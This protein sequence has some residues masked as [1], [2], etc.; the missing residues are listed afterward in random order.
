MAELASPQ[1]LQA[2]PQSLLLVVIL[3]GM[4]QDSS[5]VLWAALVPPCHP[6]SPQGTPDFHPAAP[7][8][9]SLG[10]QVLGE[11]WEWLSGMKM[12]NEQ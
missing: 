11:S 4:H 8:T 5:L 1:V 7:A 2:F 10:A 3:R 6:L 9:A 12:G